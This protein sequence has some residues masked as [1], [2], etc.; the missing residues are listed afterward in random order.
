MTVRRDSRLA[1]SGR[2]DAGPTPQ[3]TITPPA[4]WIS[5]VIDSASQLKSRENV[6]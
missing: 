1:G 6:V 5:Q 4:E 2:A 3:E